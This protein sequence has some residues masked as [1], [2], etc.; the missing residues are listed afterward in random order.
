MQV[1]E[2]STEATGLA[3]APRIHGL[4]RVRFPN[5]DACVPRIESVRGI[6]KPQ[7]G[8]SFEHYCRNGV[9][10]S[11]RKDRTTMRFFDL[12]DLLGTSAYFSQ[13]GQVRSMLRKAGIALLTLL[14]A[15]NERCPSTEITA[16]VYYSNNTF[17]FGNEEQIRRWTTNPRLDRFLR[18]TIAA[19][20]I[21]SLSKKHGLHCVPRTTLDN[22]ADCYSCT[23]RVAAEEIDLTRSLLYTGCTEN[24]TVA[25]RADIGPGDTATSMTYWEPRPSR[26]HN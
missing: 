19:D 9:R 7:E 1:M 10:C 22:C 23:G 6:R 16:A 21:A 25:I 24:G 8:V 20:G 2:W 26:R 3:R 5:S 17:W 14:C 12:H 15:C 18:S 11:C 13:G 4:P